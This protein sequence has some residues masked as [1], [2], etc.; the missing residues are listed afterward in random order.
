MHAIMSRWRCLQVQKRWGKGKESYTL[1]ELI[2]PGKLGS[3]QAV[4]DG[5]ARGDISVQT[6]DGI[7]M[8][9]LKKGFKTNIKNR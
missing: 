8:Y 7:E 5:L 2:G 9:S 1:T 3:K 6:Q 4:D